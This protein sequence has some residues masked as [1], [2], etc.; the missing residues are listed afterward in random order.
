MP[1]HSSPL[2]HTHRPRLGRIPRARPAQVRGGTL[3][4]MVIGIVLGMGIA[5]AVALFINGVPMPQL[6]R[7]TLRTDSVDQER[8]RNRNWNPNAALHSSTAAPAASAPSDAAPDIQPATTTDTTA[9]PPTPQSVAAP[10][11]AVPNADAAGTAPAVSADGF[12]YFVQ[13]G[14][15]RNV[16]DA[17]AQRAKILM[18]GWEPRLSEREENGHTIHRVR[19]GPFAKRGDAEQLREQLQDAGIPTSLIRASAQP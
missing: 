10:A 12:Q 3:A 17:Q 19:V 5:L 6:A 16:D 2:P 1:K 18:L 9:V 15:F 13:A 7:D 4:G 11:P 8:E 14:A